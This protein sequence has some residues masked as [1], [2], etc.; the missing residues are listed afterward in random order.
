MPI[1]LTCTGRLMPMLAECWL[2]DAHDAGVR[3]QS[4]ECHPPAV[5]A[6]DDARVRWAADAGDAR[7]R[8][9]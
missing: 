5:V 9:H 1:K 4:V 8:L 2:V 3:M 7:A 6:A